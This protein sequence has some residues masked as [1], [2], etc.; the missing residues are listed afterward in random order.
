MQ[1]AL[2]FVKIVDGI[3]EWVGRMVAWLVLV[4]VTVSAVNAIVRKL[5]DTSSNAWLEL[6]WYLF[7]AV[8]MLGAAWVLKNNGHVRIDVVSQRLSKW[9]R[10][11]I[12]LFC[13]LLLLLPFCILMVWLGVP[14]VIS[15][16]A[17]GEMSYN[18]GGLVVWPAKALILAGFL[19][20]LMQ[21]IAEIV[22][23]ALV[24]SGAL[25]EPEG[26]A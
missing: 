15:S 2:G 9:A 26:Q 20:L 13:H 16:W 19:L 18:A 14:Y 23:R 25:D 22:R 11:L 12:D 24:I 8:F 7:G 6:Q 4:A 21:A 1:I 5:F 3:T 10:D 17:E